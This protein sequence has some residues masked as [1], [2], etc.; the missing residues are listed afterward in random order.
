MTKTK[1]K[2]AFGTIVLQLAI[3]TGILFS[4]HNFLILPYLKK[5]S[6]YWEPW[7]IYTFHFIT[8]TALIYF[9]RHRSKIK[10][11]KVLNAFI[12]LSLLKMIA[13]VLFL[14]PLFFYKTINPTATVFSFFIPYFLYL[15][16]ETGYAVKI[17]NPTK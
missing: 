1:K 6:F 11:D 15:F 10:P 5:Y 3:L 9:L 8:V 12:T 14:S 7:K 13:A 17:L 4:I 2:M 16:F